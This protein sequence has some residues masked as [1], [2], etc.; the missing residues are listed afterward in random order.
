MGDLQGSPA[1]L[2]SVGVSERAQTSEAGDRGPAFPPP[3]F[4]ERPEGGALRSLARR[5]SWGWGRER[6]AARSLAAR[7][8]R[9]VTDEGYEE[10]GQQPP[11]VQDS[12]PDDDPTAVPADPPPLIDSWK[13]RPF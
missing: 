13:E 3:H 2:V 1:L 8:T 4:G 5:W 11:A 10:S 12:F 7:R 6:G 9:W